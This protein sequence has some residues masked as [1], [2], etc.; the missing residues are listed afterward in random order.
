MESMDTTSS[1]TPR[2]R[3]DDGVSARRRM[4]SPRC[5]RCI[6]EC[7]RGADAVV[8]VVVARVVAHG[9]LCAHRDDGGDGANRAWSAQPRVVMRFDGDVRDRERGTL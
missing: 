1:D 6:V 9:C 2:S 4:V 3:D 5:R 7:A 8:V